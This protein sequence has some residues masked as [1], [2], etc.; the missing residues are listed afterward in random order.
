MRENSSRSKH[1]DFIFL[2]IIS[3]EVSFVLANLIRFRSDLMME[4]SEYSSLNLMILL[5]HLT[6]VFASEGYSGIL[7]RGY[8]KEFKKTFF[9]NGALLT[10]ALAILF[11]AKYSD[12][13]SRLV[14]FYFFILNNVFM[15]LFRTLRKKFLLSATQ[16]CRVNRQMLLVT[17]YEDAPALVKQ[18]QSYH[19]NDFCLKGIC[20]LDSNHIGKFIEETE[21]VTDKEHLFAYLKNNVVDAVFIK[22]RE[23]ERKKLTDILYHMGIS[24]HMCLDS[25][26]EGIPNATIENING[27]TVIT[28]A[29]H[30]PTVRQQFIKRTLDICGSVVGLVLTGIIYVIFAPIILIQSPGTVFFKQ[31]RV[32]KHGRRFYI[33]KFRSMYPDAEERKAELMAENQMSGHMFKLDNDPRVIPI[34]RFMRKTSLDEFPQF[35]NVLKGDMSLVGTRPPTEDEYEK[36]EMHHRSRLAIK[37]GLTG[38]WQ[39]S[40]RSEITDFEEIVELDKKYIRTFCISQDIKIL[41]KTVWVVLT[42]R[43]AK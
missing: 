26:I 28:A 18:L 40:G 31:V 6:I 42:G 17:Y 24:V 33:Y 16:K 12:I 14:L 41:L 36:Y 5:L 34:G 1:L 29:M 4:S 25:F 43:G 32:G 21:I 22:C 7:R 27:T 10:I 13:Y 8:A 30:Q 19:Y 20:I 37:P 2:D 3:V 15:Y 38:L 39:V 11:F 35:W 9:H 23:S